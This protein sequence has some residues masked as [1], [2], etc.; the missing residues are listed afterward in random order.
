MVTGILLGLFLVIATVS[1]AHAQASVEMCELNETMSMEFRELRADYANDTAHLKT[2]VHIWQ[3]KYANLLAQQGNFS[4]Q[5]QIANLTDRVDA[6]E[7]KATTNES[8]IYI[9]QNMLRTVQT[10]IA[11]IFLKINSVR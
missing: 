7:T 4:T 3:L 9:V 1:V 11:D 8:L 10:D 6:V 5:D 2:E